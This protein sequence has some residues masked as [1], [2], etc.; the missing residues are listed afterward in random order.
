MK[1]PFLPKSEALLIIW[2]LNLLAKFK[3]VASTLGYTLL[4]V[5]AIEKDILAIIHSIEIEGF[6]KSKLK[7]FTTYKKILYSGVSIGLVITPP[8]QATLPTLTDP[9]EPGA[10]K[11]ILKE[12]KNIKNNK[13]YTSNMGND[14]GIIGT[15][16]IVDYNEISTEVKLLSS[17]SNGIKIKY[18]KK[19]MS[20]ADIYCL[21]I[22]SGSDISDSDLSTAVFEKISSIT[23]TVY[24]DTRLNQSRQ[25]EIRI[26]K[27]FLKK[28]DK[29]VGK[30]SN[31]LR[32][33]AEVYIDAQGNELP[34][35]TT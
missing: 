22:K 33:V 13:N 16:V 18:I 11:R 5:A 4:Q 7:D 29:V 23:G 20:G 10:M 24:E 17:L 12:I 9:V 2:L 26:Y 19:H 27:A 31:Y 21:T 25:P 32:V 14:M 28:G 35:K 30:T 15:E 6:M 3:L 8:E 1:K 34:A